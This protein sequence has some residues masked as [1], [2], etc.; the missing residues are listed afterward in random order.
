MNNFETLLWC[1]VRQILLCVRLCCAKFKCSRTSGG[2]WIM[3]CIR[4]ACI[5]ACICGVYLGRYPY[6]PCHRGMPPWHGLARAR[7]CRHVNIVCGAMSLGHYLVVAVPVATKFSSCIIRNGVWSVVPRPSL[8][9]IKEGTF[10]NIKLENTQSLENTQFSVKN[11]QLN[12]QAQLPCLVRVIM[13]LVWALQ[14]SPLPI[15]FWHPTA[16]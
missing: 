5:W 10:D 8:P 13:F 12:T 3:H 9:P 16:L 2:V 11:T 6:R 1:L 15:I 14:I 7:C 4:Q